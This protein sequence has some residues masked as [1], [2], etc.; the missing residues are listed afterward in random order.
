MQFEWW[1][2]EQIRLEAYDVEVVV[3]MRDGATMPRT[4]KGSRVA[5]PI[6]ANAAEINA[7]AIGEKHIGARVE[8]GLSQAFEATGKPGKARQID[9]IPDRDEDIG[10]LGPGFVREE[11]AEHRDTLHSCNAS[12]SEN[13]VASE[14]E[15]R[16][17]HFVFRA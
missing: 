8:P 16:R 5:L 12:R 13:E 15:E 11:G 9:V 4:T 1:G 7:F 17:A 10:V 2:G 3:E 14:L 6:G